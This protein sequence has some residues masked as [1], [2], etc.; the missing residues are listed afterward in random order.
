MKCNDLFKLIKNLLKKSF[1]R[2]QKQQ[3]QHKWKLT[4]FKVHVQILAL[5]S[6]KSKTFGRNVQIIIWVILLITA[7]YMW[8]CPF[9]SNKRPWRRKF[10]C[11]VKFLWTDVV[12]ILLQLVGWPTLCE[13]VWW[14]R[15]PALDP[16][17]GWNDI[18]EVR[19]D[20][21]CVRA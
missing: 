20:S 13:R 18:D 12:L 21:C 4:S 6:I 10:V 8:S 5:V 16:I 9:Y 2:N 1:W 11:T 3:F 7:V 15:I 14:Q 19:A 17:I